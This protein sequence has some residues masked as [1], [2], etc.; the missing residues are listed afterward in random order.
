MKLVQSGGMKSLSCGPEI[1]SAG[2]VWV[3]SKCCLSETTRVTVFIQCSSAPLLIC[4]RVY[5]CVRVRVC[6]CG[7]SV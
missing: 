2:R 7:E 1:W 3:E 4:V 6:A 5:E